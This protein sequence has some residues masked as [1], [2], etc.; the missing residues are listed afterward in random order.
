MPPKRR[1]VEESACA[2]GWNSRARCSSLRPMPVS[3]HRQRDARRAVAERH[4]AGAH[5]H[6]AALGELQALP[7]RLNRICRTRVGSPTSASLEPGCDR[8][9]ERKSLGGRLRPERVDR[10]GDQPGQRECGVLQLQPAGL[11][12]GEVEQVVDDAQQRL[13]GIRAW[14]RRSGAAVSS[15]PWCSSTSIM[16]STPFIGV[17]ISWLMVARKVDL[18]WVAASASAARRSRP[19]P[20]RRPAPPRAPSAR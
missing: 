6:A 4:G 9:V 17:R 20:W 18:A 16:P 11:D 15:S 8:G 19:P 10:A 3:L 7:S 5:L 13:R 12:L 2:N 1:V 14:S